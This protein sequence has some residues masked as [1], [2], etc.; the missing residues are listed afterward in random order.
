MSTV[1]PPGN[2][3]LNRSRDQEWRPGWYVALSLFSAGYS[4]WSPGH[5]PLVIARAMAQHG[6]TFVDPL[7]LSQPSSL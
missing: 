4:D 2:M 5:D 7:K 3:S 6:I 1:S